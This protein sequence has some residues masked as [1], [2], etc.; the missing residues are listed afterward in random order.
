MGITGGRTFY[1]GAGAPPP[2]LWSGDL[3]S[4]CTLHMD[5]QL[6]EIW[7]EPEPPRILIVHPDEE[8][9][10]SMAEQLAEYDVREVADGEQAFE[11]AMA[12]EPDAVIANYSMPVCSGEELCKRLRKESSLCWVP[13]AIITEDEQ[14]FEAS[15]EAGASEVVTV[16]FSSVELRLR[17]RNMVRGQVYLRE[18]ERKN[19]VILEALNDLR[20][21][22]A[23]LVQAEKLSLLGE[24]SA[25]IVHEI[26]N[27]LNYS[28]SA[29]FVMQRMVNEMEEGEDKEEYDELVGD[30]TDGLERVGHIV[31]DLRAFAM[32]GTVQ[33]TEVDLFHVV[34]TSTR[35]IGN[36]LS[37]ICYDERMTE[38]LFVRGNEN[39][40]C[41]VILNLIKNGV[42]ATEAAGRSLEEAEIRVTGAEDAEGVTLKV[43]DNGCGISDKDR[44]SMFEPFYTTK[45]RGRGMGLGL[46][47]CRRILEDHGATIEVDSREG[48]FTEFTL[49]FP[50]AFEST[51]ERPAAALRAT[52]LDYPS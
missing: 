40:L 28:K 10:R 39:N 11:L 50:S 7:L 25:G 46:S 44:S 3:P 9:R 29:L 35:L 1:G 27:P 22:E 52:A 42:E 24:M 8:I 31:R 15:I 45:D 2:R 43:R 36:R 18:L 23:M 12:D 21:S 49:S 14:S 38:G 48:E 34:R 26:N 6:P 4:S 41:Q 37:N 5:N 19:R 17:L 51:S 33:V 32:K 30:I 20:E 16:P 47:I 13:V